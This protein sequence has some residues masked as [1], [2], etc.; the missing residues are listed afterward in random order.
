MGKEL[1]KLKSVKKHYKM[2]D[3]TVKA[4]DGIDILVESGDFVAIMG[5]SGSGK[6]ISK[7]SSIF[8][9]DGSYQEV[10]NLK[11]K[12]KQ[13]IFSLSSSPY[14]LGTKLFSQ[15]HERETK[16]LINIK[17]RMGNETSATPEHPLIVLDSKGLR[18]KPLK[19]LRIGDF[20]ATVR[21]TPGNY[22]TQY[23][24]PFNKLSKDKSLI[25]Y[26]SPTLLRGVR[27]TLGFS[28]KDICK[29]LGVLPGIYDCWFRSNN[30]SLYNFVKILAE[31]DKMIYPFEKGISLTGNCSNKVVKVP[32]Y[33]SPE[34]LE[35]YGYLVGDG[36]LDLR[37]IR[38]TNLDPILRKRFKKLTKS[39][40]NIE[41]KEF[42]DSRIDCNNKVIKSYFNLVLEVP[43]RKKSRTISIPEVL[44][45]MSNSEAVLFL[46]ALFDCDGY[47]SK[48]KKEIK[49]TL[50][51]KKLV[52]QLKVLLLR[53]GIVAKYSEEEK[54]ATNT[55]ERIRR[56]YYSLSISG[57]SNLTLF[58]KEIG[59]NS[60]KKKQRLEEHINS[61]SD[62]PNVDIIPCG[63]LIKEIRKNSNISF[64]RKEHKLL[65][66]IESKRRNPS[67]KKLKEIIDIFKSKSINTEGL[68]KLLS[69]DVFWD[70]IVEIEEMNEPSEVYDITVPS[71][72]NF[73]SDHFIVHNSTT[74]NLVGS[75][76]LATT[77]D[78]YLDGTNIE[79]L[80]ESELA[81]IRGKKIGFIF[82]SFN[83]I[84]NLTTKENVTLPMMFQEVPKEDRDKRAEELLKMIGLG[85][86]M[87]HYP[88]QLSGGQ[89][90]RV[91]IA[92]ALSNDPDVILADEPTGNLDTVTGNKVMDFLQDLNK[93]GKTIIMVTHEPEL[94]EEHAR[95]IYWMKDG[96]IDRVTKSSQ[97]KK[98]SKK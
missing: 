77:G 62:N 25:I 85:D 83:L 44:M 51:S 88:N 10:K 49:I 35:L 20:V 43:S 47:V 80:D 55:K 28:R 16:E 42:S 93:K 19:E 6:C 66:N 34:L 64:S 68:E 40:F 52:R 73:V 9:G 75:L 91:A 36:N 74:M 12:G 37:G 96:K 82:Q 30:I 27:R 53:F 38:L 71:T 67:K 32:L 56:T 17:T 70:K 29:S 94:A 81:Q 33:T 92:R 4:V 59:F 8:L 72:H 78:I 15:F 63:E 58:K 60:I 24:D 79:T 95:T 39:L 89:Q 69:T 26:N 46:R 3:N 86:R 87:D 57:K 48:S 90:Q 61:K 54:H 23:L 50:A 7:N 13:D 14:N 41:S 98:S 11:N 18:W 45:K 76:D 65:N 5:P 1:I 31:K 84:P 97:K 21:R 22:Q 2:G